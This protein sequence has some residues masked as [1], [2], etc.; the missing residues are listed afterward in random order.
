MNPNHI[1]YLLDPNYKPPQPNTTEGME[2][3]ISDKIALMELAEIIQANLELIDDELAQ[4][5]EPGKS[6]QYGDFKITHTKPRSTFDKAA[7]EKTYPATQYPHLYE[8]KTALIPAAALK[9]VIS[10]SEYNAFLKTSARGGS[11]NVKHQGWG[12]CEKQ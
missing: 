6:L 5:I 10:G 11:I 4:S 9:K 12:D 1:L 2:A 3:L 7:F 8:Q